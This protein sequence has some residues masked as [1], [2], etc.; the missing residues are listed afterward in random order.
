MVCL[1]ERH[2]SQIHA[3]L[4]C[5]DRI[6]I[7]GTLPGICHGD[8]MAAHLRSLGIRLFDY[9]RYTEPLR[10]ELRRNAE[11]FAQEN[12][13]EIEFIRTKGAFRKETR[14]QDILAKRGEGVGL[15]HIFS[16]MEACP[17][18][19]PWHDKQ[20][21]HNYLTGFSLA[22][23]I[24]SSWSHQKNRTYMQVLSDYNGQAC[25]NHRT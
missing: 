4:S 18:F 20:T 3:M 17:S 14:I 2:G 22:E 16:T 5:F 19:E 24:A 8:G 12:G 6:V 11:N 9:P 7:S 1:I 13:L 10:V 23:K 21:G 15:V 25:G